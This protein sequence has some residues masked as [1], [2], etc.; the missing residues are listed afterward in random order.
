[1]GRV[2]MAHGRLDARLASVLVDQGKVA[3]PNGAAAKLG[4]P[5]STLDL[6]IKQLSIKKNGVR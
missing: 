3:G 5:R 4:I 1:M 6:K 2:W